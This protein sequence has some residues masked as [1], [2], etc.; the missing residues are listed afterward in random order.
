MA[1]STVAGDAQRIVPDLPGRK[2]T[3]GCIGP[4]IAAWALAALVAVVAAG[5]V[6][7]FFPRGGHRRGTRRLRRE[8]PWHRGLSGVPVP[9][10]TD[11]QA[12]E[13]RV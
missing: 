3:R 13:R 8:R 2:A 6:A 1:D 9:R 10:E 4:K 11:G 7:S 12:R 5:V